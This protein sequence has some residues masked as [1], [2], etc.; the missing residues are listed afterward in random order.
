MSSLIVWLLGI[1][2]WGAPATASAVDQAAAAVPAPVSAIVVLAV[3]VAT[4]A[5]F[6]WRV[7]DPHRVSTSELMVLQ[8]KTSRTGGQPPDEAAT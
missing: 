4:S 7:S 3:T 5:V 2:I 6:G 8:S 1:G